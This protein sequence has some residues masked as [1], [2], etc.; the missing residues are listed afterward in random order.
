M[1]P[2]SKKVTFIA[3]FFFFSFVYGSVNEVS[4]EEKRVGCRGT[5]RY[6]FGW[7]DGHTI[8]WLYEGRF[9]LH[10]F[11]SFNRCRRVL[12]DMI[13]EGYHLEKIK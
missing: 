1:Y 12:I 13:L 11:R 6:H 7:N 2:P 3:L 8:I 10:V 9:A 5:S 4:Q